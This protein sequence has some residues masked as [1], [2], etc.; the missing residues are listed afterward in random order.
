MQALAV[1]NTKKDCAACNPHGGDL[2]NRNRDCHTCYGYGWVWDDPHILLTVR[3]PAGTLEGL[4]AYEDLRRP[5][6]IVYVMS[7][8]F[9]DEFQKPSAVP[10]PRLKEIEGLDDTEARF[11]L[12]TE[13][14]KKEDV[15]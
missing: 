5:G 8:A 2:K 10:A 14:L 1:D 9:A 3:V 4:H 11:K 12:V 13:D 7:Q 6:T 15:K